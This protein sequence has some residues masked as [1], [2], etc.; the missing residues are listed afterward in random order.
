MYDVHD[1]GTRVGGAAAAGARRAGGCQCIWTICRAIFD[2]Q[3]DA[4]HNPRHFVRHAAAGGG[5]GGST[6]SHFLWAAGDAG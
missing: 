5:S 1:R 2:R 6:S 4:F 3:F